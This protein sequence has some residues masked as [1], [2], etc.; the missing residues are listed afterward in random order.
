MMRILVFTLLV[1]TWAVEAAAEPPSLRNNPFTRPPTLLLVDNTR[2]VE[3]LG[4]APLLL[5]A[6][7]VSPTRSIAN[8]EGLVLQP[9]DEIRGFVLRQVFEDR[10]VFERGE[11]EIVVYVKPD[12]E[13]DDELPTPIPRRR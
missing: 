8:V 11:K 3:D 12:M 1:L 7:M 9:G 4:G 10:A 6:T 2:P 13:E 5:I